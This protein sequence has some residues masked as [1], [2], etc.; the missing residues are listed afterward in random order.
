MNSPD[1]SDNIDETPFELA[2]SQSGVETTGVVECGGVNRQIE[3]TFG[4]FFKNKM[5]SRTK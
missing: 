1:Q 5:N 3:K 2:V 4:R